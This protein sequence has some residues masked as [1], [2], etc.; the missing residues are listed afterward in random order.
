M[1]INITT[2]VFSFRNVICAS[3][4]H[5]AEFDAG[6]GDSFIDDWFQANWERIVETSTGHA[7]SIK[8]EPYGDGADCNP[9]SSR[10][11][12]PS[13]LPTHRV[14][15]VP[16]LGRAFFD[17]INEVE[18]NEAGIFSHFCSLKDGWPEVSAPFDH[19]ALEGVEQRV[20]AAKNVGFWAQPVLTR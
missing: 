13:V 11:W 12:M 18:L 17:V 4:E 19:I 6:E 5:V 7:P 1:R 8:L 14:E 2:S 10:V 15:V 20:I 16:L 3:W 9:G